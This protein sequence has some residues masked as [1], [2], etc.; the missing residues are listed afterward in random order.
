MVDYFINDIKIPGCNPGMVAGFYIG[1]ELNGHFNSL[2]GEGF[3]VKD[4]NS[5]TVGFDNKSYLLY[6]PKKE[7]RR[8]LLSTEDMIVCLD[9]NKNRCNIPTI[10]GCMIPNIC[11]HLKDLNLKSNETFYIIIG[12][13]EELEKTSGSYELKMVPTLYRFTD[14]NIL[15]GF[16]TYYQSLNKYPNQVATFI[17]E[18]EIWKQITIPLKI[19]FRKFDGMTAVDINDIGGDDDDFVAPADFKYKML[20]FIPPVY[21]P[22]PLQDRNGTPLVDD[23]DHPL[24]GPDGKV[25]IDQDKLIM[26]KFLEEKRKEDY[27]TIYDLINGT[28]HQKSLSPYGYTRKEFVRIVDATINNI[29]KLYKK[30]LENDKRFQ[31]KI[32]GET[33]PLLSLQNSSNTSPL[34]SRDSS[35]NNLK[36][37]PADGFKMIPPP[38][39]NRR[40]N[41]V[42]PGNGMYKNLKMPVAGQVDTD[43]SELIS[44]T[45]PY[46]DPSIDPTSILD[47]YFISACKNGKNMSELFLELIYPIPDVH[48]HETIFVIDIGCQANKED[49][50][51]A[52]VSTIDHINP[53]T[54]W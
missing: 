52:P 43:D 34:L 51:P 5:K 33:S 16:F 11:K 24:T 21:T 27:E 53:I 14:K 15:S 46:E 50:K 6:Q 12:A 17:V 28:L 36:K 31:S 49:N 23:S 26:F 29:V 40:R 18:K 7:K 39:P 35:N 32:Y 4:S 45:L 54:K 30:R 48:N 9:N 3:T 25:M 19:C 38:L 1:A 22:I 10:I 44:T 42:P 20:S 37:L 47:P 8:K 2:T 13:K 41:I